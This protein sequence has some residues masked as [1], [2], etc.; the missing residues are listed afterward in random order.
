[1]VSKYAILISRYILYSSII[2]KSGIHAYI[3]P[4][5]LTMTTLLCVCVEQEHISLKLCMNFFVCYAT[6]PF[7]YNANLKLGQKKPSWEFITFFAS[8]MFGP[9]F[10]FIIMIIDAFLVQQ[11][12]ALCQPNQQFSALFELT[13]LHPNLHALLQHC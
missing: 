3:S 7:H 5:F 12:V 8:K 9:F 11:N 6:R 4:I 10:S 13:D 1:M 2:N